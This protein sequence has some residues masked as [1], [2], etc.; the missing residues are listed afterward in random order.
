MPNFDRT[1]DDIGNVIAFEHV[2]LRVPA[3]EIATAFYVAALGLTRDPHMM[4]GTNNMWVNIGHQQFHLPRGAAQRFRGVINVMIPYREALLAR[5]AH[6]RSELDGTMFDYCEQENHVVVTCP[7]G[8][9]LHVY[10]PAGAREGYRGITSLEMPTQTGTASGI[11]AFYREAL[12]APAEVIAAENGTAVHVTVGA[13]QTLIYRESTQAVP[14][15]DGHHIAIY[16]AD[17]SGPYHWLR[18]RGLITREDNDHQYRFQDIVTHDREHPAFSLEHEVRS[19]YH[20]LWRRDLVNRPA[21][22]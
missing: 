15:Y 19:L 11:A 5:L 21:V 7:W 6:A 4:V 8:N 2:N 10:E 12:R 14:A 18:E 17:F 1:R 20:P 13:A 3:Q 9:T 16:V 22:S